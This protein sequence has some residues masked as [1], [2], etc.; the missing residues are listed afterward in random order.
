MVV[1][2]TDT[3]RAMSRAAPL[4]L[5]LSRDT[6]MFSLLNPY[7]FS[8]RLNHVSQNALNYTLTPYPALHLGI[9][10]PDINKVSVVDTT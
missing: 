4:S 8:R 6:L 9:S 3:C 2:T 7:N 1:G 10:D 5:L